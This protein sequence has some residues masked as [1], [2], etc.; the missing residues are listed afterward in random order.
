M[1]QA[2]GGSAGFSDGGALAAGMKPK[3]F[4]DARKG[5][6]REPSL[7]KGDASAAPTRLRLATDLAAAEEEGLL[8]MEAYSTQRIAGRTSVDQP[9]GRMIPSRNPAD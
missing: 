2:A 7:R 8:A 5:R 3:G 1:S 9:K 6:R 4:L